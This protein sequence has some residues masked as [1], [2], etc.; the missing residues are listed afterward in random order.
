VET[1]KERDKFHKELE[2]ID[3]HLPGTRVHTHDDTD[4]SHDMH[5]EVDEWDLRDFHR[6]TTLVQTRRNVEVGSHKNQPTSRTGKDGFLCH[7]RLGL[8]GWIAYWCL[9]ET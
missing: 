9:G 8:V 6:E 4:D 2:L 1:E 3:V 7:T 5:T